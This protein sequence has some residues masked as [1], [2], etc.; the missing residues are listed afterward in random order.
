MREVQFMAAAV[1]GSNPSEAQNQDCTLDEQHWQ[2]RSRGENESRS[3]HIWNHALEQS[4]HPATVEHPKDIPPAFRTSIDYWKQN[5]SCRSDATTATNAS[6]LHTSLSRKSYG[7][8]SYKEANSAEIIPPTEDDLPAY[9]MKTA[10]VNTHPNN[11][12]KRCLRTS[13]LADAFLTKVRATLVRDIANHRKR[14]P[15]LQVV[16]AIKDRWPPTTTQKFGPLPA[17]I[18]VH[19]TNGFVKGAEHASQSIS[20]KE[21]T[22]A[23]EKGM[24]RVGTKFGA[25]DRA[26]KTIAGTLVNVK[27]RRDSFE[28]KILSP[29]CAQQVL[30]SIPDRTVGLPILSSSSEESIVSSVTH[31]S[32]VDSASQN[33]NQDSSTLSSTGMH[34]QGLRSSYKIQYRGGREWDDG[35]VD[36]SFPSMVR[37]FV[38]SDVDDI[39]LVGGFGSA[40]ACLP[41]CFYGARNNDHRF[42][43]SDGYSERTAP[44]VPFTDRRFESGKDGLCPTTGLPSIP[45]RSK[46]VCIPAIWQTRVSEAVDGDSAKR[47][48]RLKRVW[49][50]AQAGDLDDIELDYV[51]DESDLRNALSTLLGIPEHVCFP[52]HKE[53]GRVKERS[54][55][56]TTE[57]QAPSEDLLHCR[58]HSNMDDDRAP[59]GAKAWRVQRVWDRE[60]HVVYVEDEHLLNESGLIDFFGRDENMPMDSLVIE[61]SKNMASPHDQGTGDKVDSSIDTEAD[62]K[63]ALDLTDGDCEKHTTDS[64]SHSS[65]SSVLSDDDASYVEEDPLDEL[66]FAASLELETSSSC[67]QH[68]SPNLMLIR[69]KLLKVERMIKEM[70]Q[71]KGE[72]ASKNKLYRRLQEKCKKYLSEL[73]EHLAGFENAAPEQ[74]F[75][76]Q[77][78]EKIP[79]EISDLS[80]FDMCTSSGRDDKDDVELMEMKGSKSECRAVPAESQRDQV[81]LKRKLH[82]TVKLLNRLV[83]DK[84]DEVKSTRIY[85]RLHDKRC[86][87]MEDLGMEF[88]SFDLVSLCSTDRSDSSSSSYSEISM[89]SS[90]RSMLQAI[91]QLDVI[92]EE[93]N[94]SYCSLGKSNRDSLLQR[95]IHKVGKEMR[96]IKSEKGQKAESNKLYQRLGKKLIRYRAELGDTDSRTAMDVK[97]NHYKNI[98]V[99]QT[100]IEHEPLRQRVHC[101]IPSMDPYLGE[102][103]DA[104]TIVVEEEPTTT[105]TTT[106]AR[107]KPFTLAS[108]IP[109]VRPKAPSRPAYNAVGRW[110]SPLDS[111]PKNG[112]SK[113]TLHSLRSVYM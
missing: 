96:K 19:D 91:D 13:A 82:K 93:E 50:S 81:A 26:F 99:D 59:V 64:E 67:S 88:E 77:K 38:D 97:N 6:T 63:E 47:K 20:A 62:H 95:K 32:D 5:Y 66:E 87:Y 113:L 24:F 8:C 49:E 2:R 30:V 11:G 103:V 18:G 84:G 53:G 22:A 28:A 33:D 92:A 101:A 54:A 48:W 104:N 40:E 9:L 51:V 37:R 105:A 111:A 41:T 61:A 29:P 102:V 58:W 70:V 10:S 55:V 72:K 56:T 45:Y 60:G 4:Q 85:K 44:G 16:K 14:V 43:A 80:K 23:F 90:L 46:D 74:C 112:E 27:G 107:L 98:T 69:K 89:S 106:R 7:D 109:E 12:T 1:V 71:E 83:V 94:D 75:N 39:S 100:C 52:R 57:L 78:L 65:C 34:L 31:Q 25:R 110:A 21:R 68:G 79:S 86:G 15:S 3:P 35:M 17:S 108:P 76:V 36:A 73:S 42:A